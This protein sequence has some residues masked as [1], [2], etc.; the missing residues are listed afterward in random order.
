VERQRGPP[1]TQGK[2]TGRSDDVQGFIYDVPN[3][4]GGVAYTRTN[5]EIARHVGE[6][7]TT[8][9]PYVRTAILT[10]NVP[11]PTRPT[12]PTAVGEPPVIDPVEQEIFREKIQ[13]YV[14]TEAAIDTDMKFLYDLLW[15]Q[16][17]ESVRSRLRGSDAFAASSTTADSI[18]LFKSI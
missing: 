18:A 8:V 13:M 14:K 1:G 4:R 16:C 17:T 12:A 2:F 15:G 11:S 7:Y 9:G 3:S 5:E 6:K 10:L